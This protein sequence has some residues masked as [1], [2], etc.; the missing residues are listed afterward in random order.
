MNLTTQLATAWQ[1]R[2]Q[3]LG[4]SAPA[5]PHYGGA[6]RTYLR[7]SV[8]TVLIYIVAGLLM[9]GTVMVYSASIG[10]SESSLFAK[11][12]PTHFLWRQM[13]FIAVSSLL[14]WAAFQIPLAQWQKYSPHLFVI[15]LVLLLIV[16]T[17]LGKAANNARRWIPIGG[18]SIQPSELMKLAV[19]IF[20][21]S[22]CVRKQHL[23]TDFKQGMLPMLVAIVAVSGLL[24]AEPDLGALVVVAAVCIGV[25]FIGG[26]ALIPLGLMSA[27]VCI[28]ATVV[29]MTSARAKRVLAFLDPF[30]P[31]FA[32]TEGFQLGNSLI[33]LARGQGTGKGLGNSV[34]KL[35]HLTEAHTDFILAIIGEEFGFIGVALV[36][37]LFTVLIFKAFAVGR[38]ALRDGERFGGLVA[39]GIGFWLALQ[40]GI[41]LCVNAGAMPTKGL[42][43]PFISYGGSAMMMSL[44]TMAL[45]LR[46]DYETRLR[47]R[48]QL[49]Q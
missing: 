14:A 6:Q 47:E 26:S 29:I 34:E 24:L 7:P 12:K 32:K 4:G 38:A 33:A 15:A 17:P 42:T 16:L 39:H 45:L 8:D 36:V 28:A 43:L 23:M 9:F 5:Q 20:T 10:M 49:P 46:V 22:Y 19:I 37:G 3:W 48:G 18:F 35:N 31:E 2:P 1:N 11:F 40:A 44:V 27:G 21:A 30:S 25:M 13:A 41:H